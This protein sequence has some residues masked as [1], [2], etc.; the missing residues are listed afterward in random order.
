[1]VT[2]MDHSSIADI[3]DTVANGATFQLNR[4]DQVYM[5]LAANTHI[6][7]DSQRKSTFSSFLLF[8]V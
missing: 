3:A 1:V 7:D 5:R 4:G 2:A 8:T 6:F